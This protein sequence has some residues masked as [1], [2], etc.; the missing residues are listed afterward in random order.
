MVFLIPTWTLG[1]P[2]LNL[3]EHLKGVSLELIRMHT[4]VD[5]FFLDLIFLSTLRIKK[6]R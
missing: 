2:E 5:Q 3:F 4:R 1:E 6:R